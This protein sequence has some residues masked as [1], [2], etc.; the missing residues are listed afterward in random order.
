MISNRKKCRSKSFTQFHSKIYLT[1]V[2]FFFPREL[3][4]TAKT[5]AITLKIIYLSTNSG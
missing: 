4:S 2:S 3:N 1:S 5:S